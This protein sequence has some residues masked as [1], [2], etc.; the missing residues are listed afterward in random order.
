MH[1]ILV[2]SLGWGLFFIR[3]MN[4]IYYGKTLAYIEF[5]GKWRYIPMTSKYK[6]FLSKL[7]VISKSRNY[8]VDNTNIEKFIDLLKKDSYL[9][10]YRLD[11]LTD[12]PLYYAIWRGQGYIKQIGKKFIDN[13]LKKSNGYD[14]C[15]ISNLDDIKSSGKI[16]YSSNS[17]LC[18]I[19]FI[20]FFDNFLLKVKDRLFEDD[21]GFNY[22]MLYMLNLHPEKLEFLINEVK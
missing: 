21:L 9:R 13:F 15:G 19:D 8:I 3:N 14:F 12:I 1:L 22:L 16:T 20:W 4:I 2:F 6:E 7:R 5:S 18:S 11:I 10:G 17:D